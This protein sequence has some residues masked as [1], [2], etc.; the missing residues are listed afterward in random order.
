MTSRPIVS[1]FVAASVMSLMLGCVGVVGSMGPA[2]KG[3]GVAKTETRD[4]GAFT[5]IQIEGSGNVTITVDPSQPPSFVLEADDNILPLVETTVHGDTLIISS[6]ESYSTRIGVRA[7]VV[8]ASLEA[9]HIS[10]SGDLV[11]HG[12]N[13]KSFDTHIT[14]SGNIKLDGTTSDLKVNVSGS[15]D[16]DTTKLAAADVKVTVSGSGDVKVNATKSIQAQI[17]GAGDI[18]YTGNPA[19]VSRHINGA[20]SIKPM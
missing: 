11:A 15:G 9:A 7:T 8:V 13:S 20:G 10:G 18:R 1:I 17:Q 16:V 19:Q 4:V 3:S 14:G 12:V 2:V 5:K 6:K